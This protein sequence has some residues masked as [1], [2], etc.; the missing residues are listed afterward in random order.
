MYNIRLGCLNDNL[1]HQLE[2]CHYYFDFTLKMTLY[3]QHRNK[4]LAIKIII[5]H[6]RDR[7]SCFP[8]DVICRENVDPILVHRSID[9]KGVNV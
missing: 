8:A 6:L 1:N 4:I 3:M 9:Q 7:E 2:N 5:Y